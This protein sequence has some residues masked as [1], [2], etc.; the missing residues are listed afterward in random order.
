MKTKDARSLPS[1]AQEDLRRKAVN[2]VLAG[3][4]QVDVARLLGVTRQ[5][6]GN[7]VK[8]YRQGGSTQLRARHKGRPRRA[9]LLPWQAAQTVRS[10][11]DRCP[12][13]LRLPFYLWTRAGVGQ[14]IKE[15]Y[16]LSLSVWTVGRY[17]KAWNLTPQKPLRRAFEQNPESVRRWLE[18][19]YPAIRAK[20]KRENAEIFWGDEMGIRSDHQ[21][22]TTYGRKGH[23]PVIAGTG[24]RFRC[25]M[26]SAITNRGRLLFMLS[27][28]GFSARLFLVFLHRMVRQAAGR[29]IFLIVD[30]HPAHR[31]KCVA[32]WVEEHEEAISLF[33]LPDYSPQLNPDEMVNQDVKANAVGRKRPEGQEHMM[34]G[35]RSYLRSRQK[36]PHIVRRYF[37]EEQVRYA[38]I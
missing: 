24:Q 28:Q 18:E 11:T 36:K 20:A 19:E 3:Q 7:W 1:V 23:T 17:L 26:I 15:R 27:K 6:V 38:A 25:H 22:G 34:C 35:V 21:T 32:R 5:A 37:H 31:A 30:G 13:Q 29:K 9:R 4:R 8:A 2:A 12:N 10:I 14:L 33:R 16:G